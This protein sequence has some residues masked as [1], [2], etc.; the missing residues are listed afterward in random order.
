MYLIDT[1]IWLEILLNQEKAQEASEFL[2]RTP[3]SAMQVTDFTVHSLGVI[4][5]RLRKEALFLEFVRDVLLAGEVAVLGVQADEM[6]ELL[7]AMRRY[8]LD[9]DDAYQYIVAQKHGVVIVSF[10][11]DFDKTDLGR[12]TPATLLSSYPTTASRKTP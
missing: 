6:A 2:S 8:S 9:F 5:C 7:E 12:K 11:H 1:N 4:L 3:T 10:D